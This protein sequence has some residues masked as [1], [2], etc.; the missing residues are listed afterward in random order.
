MVGT[1]NYNISVYNFIL[2]QEIC[3]FFCRK[4]VN[5]GNV[6]TVSVPIFSVNIDRKNNNVNTIYQNTF[7]EDS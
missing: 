4:D 7:T 2:L 5:L 1:F 3:K 6:L